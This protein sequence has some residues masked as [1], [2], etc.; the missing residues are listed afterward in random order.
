VVQNV[1]T[2]SWLPLLLEHGGAAFKAQGPLKLVSVLGAV[3]RPGVYAI[4]IGTPLGKIVELAGGMAPGKRLLAYGVGG[5]AGGFLP[6]NARETPL[7]EPALARAGAMLGAASVRVLHTGECLVREAREAVSFF[8]RESCGRCTPCRVGTTA[9]RRIF[10]SGAD[11]ERGPALLRQLDDVS[12]VL[13]QGSFCGLGRG[14]PNRL[15]SIKRY[16]PELIAAHLSGKGCPKC[17][18]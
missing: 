17:D 11:S 5:P 14:A 9:L 2:V 12:Q 16:W 1:E 7:S 8:E 6:P 3:A 10:E 4:A 18:A 13:Q 15:Q